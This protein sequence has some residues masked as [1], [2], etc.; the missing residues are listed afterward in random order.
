VAALEA[1]D[2]PFAAIVLAHLHAIWTHGDP[3]TR[4]QWKRR[5]MKGLYH[6]QWAKD[7]VRSYFSL[8]AGEGAALALRLG[9]LSR[10]RLRLAANVG[11]LVR[12]GSANRGYHKRN[13]ATL[14]NGQRD[15]AVTRAPLASP[16]KARST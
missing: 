7:D 5:I 9:H 2:N 14:P 1:S 16:S 4:Q 10:Q 8:S 11:H 15:I 12:P 13:R 6:G 3:P